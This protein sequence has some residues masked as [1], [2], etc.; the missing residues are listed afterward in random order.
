MAKYTR[1]HSINTALK[2]LRLILIGLLVGGLGLALAETTKQTATAATTSTI[3][4]NGV[5]LPTTSSRVNTSRRNRVT[6]NSLSL[7]EFGR[8]N[9]PSLIYNFAELDN[10]D[11]EP[12]GSRCKVQDMQPVLIAGVNVTDGV[13]DLE[14]A[15]MLYNTWFLQQ[16][17][18]CAPQDTAIYLPAGTFYFVSGHLTMVEGSEAWGRYER[19]VIK[20]RSYITL[21]GK[22]IDEGGLNTTLKSYSD[23]SEFSGNHKM[24]DYKGAGA[25]GCNAETETCTVS[26]GM[27]MFFY[28]QYSGHGY[29]PNY[30]DY[31][32]DADFSNFIINSEHN[33]N[34][35][36]YNTSGKG[37]MLLLIKDC[38]WDHVMVKNTD[39]TGFGADIPINSSITNSIA[40]NCG[41][42][43]TTNDGGA[44]G[45]GIG[46]GYANNESMLIS[47]SISIGN[48]KFGFFYEHQGRFNP[49]DYKATTA[50]STRAFRV[51][52]SYAENNLYNYGGLRSNNTYY[53]DS[54]SVIGSDTLLDVYFS[55]ESRDTYLDNIAI[56]G[57]TFNDVSSSDYFYEAVEWALENG[58][59]NGVSANQFGPDL[60]ITRADATILLWRM[61]NRK[62]QVLAEPNGNLQYDANGN[63]TRTPNIKTCFADVAGDAYY[64]G[65]VEWAY[66]KRIV[67][68]VRDCSGAGAKDGIFDPERIVT[69]AEFI[70]M[71]WRL[72]GSPTASG[73]VEDFTDVTDPSSYYYQAVRWAASKGITAGVGDNR[74]APTHDCTRGQ[75]VAM[76][77][78]YAKIIGIK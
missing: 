7:D 6:I 47:N 67:V 76:L 65:A 23:P 60:S 33:T 34:P 66:S 55:D 22:G 5:T 32:V 74:F 43:A 36:D 24:Y 11:K 31:L 3:Q 68:G 59:T 45:F 41:K 16:I 44:S 40:I 38:D 12:A 30:A 2:S 25:W 14:R 20:A 52:D 72:A 56:G 37:F 10:V 27:D 54:V 64:A 8:S 61:I 71:L 49:S 51:V 4:A 19:H 28:N 18:Y 69:R 78:R 15:A 63:P 50:A 48:K 57:T 9:L 62:G 73:K 13:S 70:T 42:A 17:M 39:A 46:T 1:A 26:G 58:V 29:D 53:A 75:I 21:I 77:Y 35:Y